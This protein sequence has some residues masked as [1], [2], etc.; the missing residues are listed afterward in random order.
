MKVRVRVTIQIFLDVAVRFTDANGRF[1]QIY[2]A[3]CL[4]IYLSDKEIP[5]YNTDSKSTAR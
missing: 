3:I 1:L 2:L 4:S 5:L